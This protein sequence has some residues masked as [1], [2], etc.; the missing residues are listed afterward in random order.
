M[1]RHFF[2]PVA[3]V[4]SILTPV[5]AETDLSLV[6]TLHPLRTHHADQAE[7]IS[8]VSDGQ[9]QK[10]F[11]RAFDSGNELFSATFKAVEG[12]GANVGQGLRFTRV[13][14]ADLTGAGEWANHTPQRTTGPNAQSCSQCHFKPADDGAGPAVADVHRDP[15]RTG[16]PAAFIRRNAPHLFGAGAV[17]RLAEEMTVELQGI[18]DEAA[19]AACA[20]GARVERPLL[21]KGI[22][23]GTIAAVC[24]SLDTSHVE[25]V[26]AD[27]VVRPYQ[28]KGTTAS[29]R[30]FTRDAA[31]NELGMQAV[32]LVGDDIDGDYDGVANEMTVGDMTALA[33][34][35]AAQP[36][37]TSRIELASLGLTAPL[38]DEQKDAINRGKFV[39]REIGCASCHVPSLRIDRPVFSEPS[40]NPNYRDSVFPA[41]QD[42]ISRGVDPDRP[43]LFD[44][45][46]DQPDNRVKDTKDNPVSLGSFKR[47]DRGRAVV[48]LYGDLKRH[49]MGA[50]LAEGIDEA[51]TGPAVFL[52]E[53]LWGVASTA[54]YLH[55]GRATTLTEAILAHGGE[56][57]ESRTAFLDLETGAQ[58]DL[59]A[60]LSN[61][62]LFKS[63]EDEE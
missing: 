2:L 11:R 5:T 7:F 1:R 57:A 41:G 14:R 26:G 60:F 49:D 25:G 32:E 12:G 15:F 16:N 36:R 17:Q 52:T 38:P 50:D 62:R 22:A 45:T 51:G 43:I 54:P 19:A 58:R 59:I 29:L 28:W 27:L 8:L 9:R 63:G 37:P 48:E 34:Y 40:Q 61:L 3:I 55:D 46:R 35:L 6:G 42:P 47:D 4:A 44:L 23:F 53:N 30:D 18:R 33:I 20:G 13:P 56:G 31:H 24:G 21:A 39:F 10:A